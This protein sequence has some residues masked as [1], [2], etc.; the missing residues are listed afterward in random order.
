MPAEL[1]KALM[2]KSENPELWRASLKKK[3]GGKNANTLF[4][5]RRWLATQTTTRRNHVRGKAR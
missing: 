5:F 2:H 4:V 1:E 3:N